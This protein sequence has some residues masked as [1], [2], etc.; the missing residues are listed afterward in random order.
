MSTT[1][2]IPH[3]KPLYFSYMRKTGAY[4]LAGTPTPNWQRMNWLVAEKDQWLSYASQA[5]SFEIKWDD[6]ASRDKNLRID[7][8]TLINNTHKYD[9]D[10]HM[11]DRT[12]AQSPTTALIADYTTFGITHNIPDPSH[13]G[14]AIQRL[15][16]T[17]DN[18][19]FEITSDAGGHIH[20]RCKP[21]KASKRA[22]LLKGFYV[23]IF[24]EILPQASPAPDITQLSEHEVFTKSRFI[25][26]LSGNSG[27]KLFIAARWRHKTNPALNGSLGA[28]QSITIG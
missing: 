9:H 13:T 4:L 23:E 21:S 8:D 2:R 19:Y 11:L 7:V 20:V 16:A 3:S 22:H 17:P 1:S 5:A 14:Q 15:A 24:Y 27:K 6:K 12:A 26:D 10:N 25:L 18:V 28:I